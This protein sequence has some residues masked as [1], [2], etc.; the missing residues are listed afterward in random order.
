M[1]GEV[2]LESLTKRFRDVE[3]HLW[4]FGPDGTV[5]EFRHVADTAKHVEA[6]TAR[7]LA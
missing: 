2:K 6:A 3:V 4:T 5:T 7:A 1:E